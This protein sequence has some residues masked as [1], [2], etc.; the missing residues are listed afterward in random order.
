MG[1]LPP[2]V[3]RL[4][5]DVDADGLAPEHARFI[6]ERVLD[7]GDVEACRWLLRT[8]PREEIVQVVRTSRRLARKS[9]AFWAAYFGL[10]PQEVASLRL[11]RWQGDG[12]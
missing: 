1:Q 11:P 10:D 8:F 4:F 9:A 7:W 2:E 3:R 5:W 12:A 6:I